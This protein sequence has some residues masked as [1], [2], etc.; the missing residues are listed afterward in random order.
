MAVRKPTAQETENQIPALAREA[1]RSAYRRALNSGGSVLISKNGEIRRINPD[2][3]SSVV[4]KLAPRTKMRK[5][6]IIKIK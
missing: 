1:T 4:K 5:G 3:T 2:G 6:T